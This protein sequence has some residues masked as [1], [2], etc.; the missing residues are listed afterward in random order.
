MGN[1]KESIKLI[2]KTKL[3]EL[4]KKFEQERINLKKTKDEII[5]EIEQTSDEKKRL[6]KKINSEKEKEF[7]KEYEKKFELMQD[8]LFDKEFKLKNLESQ[9]TESQ[10]VNEG[11]KSEMNTLKYRHDILESDFK[12]L[13][14]LHE[15]VI[16]QSN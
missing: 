16:T 12:Q 2:E 13:S 10:K 15:N 14:F 6:Y 3:S 8:K 11:L 5:F 7:K 4:K 9:L 1:E